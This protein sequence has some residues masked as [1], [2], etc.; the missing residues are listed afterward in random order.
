MARLTDLLFIPQA[1]MHF[2]KP[3][4]LLLSLALA[5]MFCPA[6]SLKETVLMALRQYP[7]ISAAQAKVTSTQADITRAQAGHW[8][9]LSWS[10]TQ[11]HYRDNTL[12][13]RWTHAPTLSLNLWSGW[14][15]QSDVRRSQ[16][17][18][19]ASQQ[20]LQTT[21]DDV[22]LLA[23]E[24]Y[25]QW[26][27]QRQMVR[28][29]EE[30]WITHEKILADF[31]KIA[32][33][34]PGRRI[35]LNQAEVRFE[36]ARL[37]VLRSLNDLS[38]ASQRMRRVLKGELPQEPSGLMFAPVT[39]YESAEQAL[40]GLNSKHPV[41]ANLLAEIDAA[42]ANVQAAQA[43]YSPTLNL[44]HTKLINP[45]GPSGPYTTQLQL[46]I[47]LVD[48]GTTR[49]HVGMARA[50]LEAL[51]H[52]LSETRLVLEEKLLTAWADAQSARQRA[53]IGWQQTLTA[54]DLTAGYRQQFQVGRRSLLDLLN[55]QSD[56]FAYQSNALN[57]V[58]EYRIAQARILATLGELALAY[59]GAA[60]ETPAIPTPPQN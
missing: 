38:S 15:I 41:I 55:I 43:Q 28:L 16:A 11:S 22:A 60:P 46:N 29:A 9:Q 47:P 42:Q 24:A 14:R 56:Y 36:N 2:Y 49:G 8:P 37:S 51:Q 57:A 45:V 13:D 53:E 25:L 18:A 26:A 54:K 12:N 23:T 21:H 1:V 35:D 48:G 34:D 20:Q 32:D 30:N 59:T 7:S 10:G 19:L 52:N 4:T 58:V 40:E 27:H 39:S 44:T 3:G 50:N 6:Q 17:L 31:Q 5:P 33:V